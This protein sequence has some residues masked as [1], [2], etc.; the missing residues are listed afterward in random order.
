MRYGDHPSTAALLALVAGASAFGACADGAGH[1]AT[2]EVVADLRA[3]C[4]EGAA[5]GLPE[6]RLER[7]TTAVPWPRGLVVVD[8]ELI[9]LARGRHRRAGGVDASIE[10]HSGSLFRVDTSVAEPVSAGGTAG[11]AVMDNAQVLVGPDPDVFH[12]YDPGGG[13][14]V[15][16][17]LLDR[18]YCTLAFD[19]ASAC[20]FIC[21]YSGVD[22]P[23]ARFR[24]NATDSIH[25][26]DTRDGSWHAVEMHDAAVVPEDLERYVVPNNHY[27][28][29]DPAE[30]P[31]PHGWLNGP[32][33]AEV[34]GEYL[35]AVGKD[36]HLLVQYDLAGIRRDPGA[37]PPDSR[38]LLDAGVDVRLGGEVRTIRALGPSA[39]AA[40]DGFLY[41]GYRTSS[42]VLRFPIDRRGD[43]LRPVVGELI[44]VFSPWDVEAG[45][46]ADLVDIA[47]DPEGRLYV[48]CAQRGRV[49]CVGAPD[50][51]RPF[52]GVDVVPGDW[53]PRSRLP[54]GWEPEHWEVE[55]R[56]QPAGGDGA[57]PTRNRPF[58]DLPELTGNPVARVGNIAFDGEGTL[59]LC[60]GN[61]D[62]GTRLAGVIYRAVRVQ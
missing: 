39:V 60:S 55:G 44:A 19:P 21:G 35:Y 26:F 34:V 28:H 46:S 48:S 15:D 25:R 43:L 9:V 27:P 18:P 5:K 1:A 47:F 23:G 10:D 30:G 33:G 49:W 14:P 58:I 29:H 61:Y 51:S 50:P 31:A 53:L 32:N 2:L 7:V 6:V 4:G 3:Y 13:P 56:P 57:E 40:R 16:A 45:K 20:Y 59:Y 41:L 12:L 11:P 52:D 36:N 37:G 38:P 62:S 17:T 24:K 42:L 22:L 54:E 8:G